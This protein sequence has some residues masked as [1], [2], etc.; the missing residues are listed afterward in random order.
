MNR[1]IDDNVRRTI[2]QAAGII[3]CSD[4]C[5]KG[6]RADQGK[7]ITYGIHNSWYD[8]HQVEIPA[9][10]TLLEKMQYRHDPSLPS[11]ATQQALEQEVQRLKSQGIRMNS[12]TLTQKTLTSSKAQSVLK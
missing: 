6:C 10:M 3:V 4:P 9:G 5:H 12:G 8:L 1:F 7:G 11:P 2:A